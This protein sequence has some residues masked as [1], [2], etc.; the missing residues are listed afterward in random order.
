M[1]KVIQSKIKSFLESKGAYV[2]KVIQATKSGVPDLLVC[3][4]GMFI[5]IEVKKPSTKN[6]VSKLQQHNLNLIR[7]ADGV[8]IVAWEL[9]MVVELLKELDEK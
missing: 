8:G 1:E 7:L 3:Y 9:D 6:N 5:G 4:K 2:V